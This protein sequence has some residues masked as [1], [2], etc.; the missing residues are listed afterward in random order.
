MTTHGVT[1]STSTRRLATWPDAECEPG[2]EQHKQ[3]QGKPVP[4]MMRFSMRSLLVEAVILLLGAILCLGPATG[5]TVNASLGGIVTDGAGAR[6]AGASVTL[7]NEASKDTRKTKTNGE[8]VYQFSAIPAGSYT[9]TVEHS[10]FG[11]YTESG[12]ELHPNDARTLPNVSLKVGSVSASV[13]VAAQNEVIDTSERSSLISDEDIRRLSTVGRDVSELLKTQPGF[14]ILQSG[15]NNGLGSD[16]A[17]VG[18]GGNGLA[19]YVGNGAPG[20]GASVISDGANVTDPG[21]G[22]G[23]T[24]NVN[25]DMVSE[26]KIETSNFGAD[27]AKGPTVITVVGKSGSSEFH[28]TVYAHARTSQ[29]NTEDWFMKNQKLQQIPDRYIYPG[30]NVQ[31][32]LLIPGTQFNR[33]KKVVFSADAEDY[34]QRNVYS[35]GSALTSFINA[36]VPTDQS[37]NPG[38]E[39]G[40]RQGNFSQAELANYIGSTVD[41]IMGTAANNYKDAQ[42]TPTGTLTAYYHICA[43]P[44]TAPYS[45]P[46]P[47]NGSIITIGGLGGQFANGAAS[48][49][50]GAAALLKAEFPLPTG[51]TVNGYNWRVL[52]LENPDLYQIRGRVDIAAND[53][54]KVY[55]VYNT[56]SGR[57]TGIPEQIYYSPSSGG[58]LM[59]GLDT[60]GKI[61]STATSKTASL[62]YMR[63]FSARATNEAFGA[64]SYVADYF[65]SGNPK[66]L[67]KS[68]WNYPYNG[69]YT[70]STCK[71]C[72]SDD[73]PQLGTYGD[74]SGD[75]LPLAITPDF[76]NGRYIS[77][78]FQPSGG[79]NFN[80]LIKSHTLKAGT[81]IERVT[82]NQTDLSP[83]TNGQIQSYYIPSGSFTDLAGQHNTAQCE[84]PNC[85]DNYLADFLLGDIDTFQ[86]QNYNPTTNIY[87]WTIAGFA[88]DSWKATKK[89]TVDYGL[90]IDHLSAWT[91]SH[92][93]GLAAFSPKWYAADAPS[94]GSTSALCLPGV[95]WHGNGQSGACPSNHSF[96]DM[97]SLPLSGDQT[98]FAFVSPRFGLAYDLF[99]T[100]KTVLRG[101]WGMYRSHD[102]W[103]DFSPDAGTSQGLVV[104]S[105]G[106]AGISL[107]GVDKTEGNGTLFCNA[108]GT[109]GCPTIAATDPTDNEQ[110]LT[111]TYSFTVSQQAPWGSA[112]EIAYVGNQSQDL[113][114]DSIQTSVPGVPYDMRNINAIKLGAMFLP[115]PNPDPGSTACN[116]APCYGQIL[117][118]QSTNVSQ[119]NDYR[120]FPF[121]TDI[122][123]SRHIVWANYNALQ[124]SWNRQKGRLNYGLN[125]TW[126]KALGVR[127]GYNNGW[128]SD[129]TNMRADYGPLAFDRTQVFNAS[130]SYDEGALFRKGRVLNGF[131][132]GW[133]LSGI[134][135]VQSGPNLQAVY[136]PDLALTGIVGSTAN[137]T[138]LNINNLTLLGTPDV[139]LMPTLTCNP[140]AHLQKNQF[141]NGQCFGIAPYGQNGPANLGY[142]RGPKWLNSDLTLQKRILLTE[143]RNVELRVSGFNFLNHPVTSFSSRYT[144]EASL[145]MHGNDFAS[146]TLQNGTN[147]NPGGPSCSAWGTTCFGY[148]G[149]KTGRRV[150]MLS[151]KFNF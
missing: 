54:N 139:T 24:Q 53:N 74:S 148:A 2:K 22:S 36:L 26:V 137:G 144:N 7:V 91:D 4:V 60:P 16:P 90:R 140:A 71:G 87:Y 145:E 121:Y 65:M 110:P 42:C 43:E 33:N 5:Q 34:V 82:A 32:P 21:N 104:S 83:L 122:M 66:D 127:G 14:S 59:G 51:P 47:T 85:G 12:I 128:T 143:K 134:T 115:D 86:Q 113:L 62:N 18:T 49:D 6:L 46:N 81:Y 101:G 142:I 117:N 114:T 147:T 150:I 76:S 99:G 80:L 37:T 11:A 124:T 93:V 102:S 28:G 111:M 27:T 20:N 35:Y 112:F 88:Q 118:P 141:V 30:F 103:N 146:A 44:F 31:G 72:G 109:T 151:A 15:L 149:Y 131:I 107:A 135:N 68:T 75:G 40:M 123:V 69:I 78:K 125:Y 3:T 100:G 92:G 39:P 48:F 10:G 19:N 133:F 1:P 94:R 64:I 120:P 55:A 89:L 130:Y 41:A 84:F 29:L 106:G 9:L 108:S 57:I 98:R 129:P 70:R 25:M 96:N 58:S 17:V 138:A 67:L 50:P 56:E 119:Q 116:G 63:V 95:R 52:N 23:Q 45:T 8:G 13:T 73:I 61:I 79:D 136:S 97:S 105:A 132:N 77:K 38:G 126:S